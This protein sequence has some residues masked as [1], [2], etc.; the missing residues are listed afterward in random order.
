[1]E[2]FQFLENNPM[3]WWLVFTI[4]LVV[5]FGILFWIFTVDNTLPSEKQSTSFFRRF[6]KRSFR[7]K[8]LPDNE[9]DNST[10]QHNE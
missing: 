3:A 7:R 4:I 8:A 10:Q 9:K 1:M 6:A 5:V 2:P